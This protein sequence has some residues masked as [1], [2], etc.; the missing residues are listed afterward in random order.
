MEID[1]MAS[2]IQMS[3]GVLSRESENDDDSFGV[4]FASAVIALKASGGW[5]A[6]PVSTQ[7]PLEVLPEEPH[8]RS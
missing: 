1:L 3:V 2:R 7:V 8:T 6:F 5:P 4:A